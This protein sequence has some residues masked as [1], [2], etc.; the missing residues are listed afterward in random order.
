MKCV[1]NNK[2]KE[3]KRVSDTQAEKLVSEGGFHYTTKSKWRNAL[4]KRGNNK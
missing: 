3:I 2:T 4:K 1:E